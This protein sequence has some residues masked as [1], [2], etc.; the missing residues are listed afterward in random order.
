MT[1]QINLGNTRVYDQ[2]YGKKGINKD[3]MKTGCKNVK[4]ME[5]AQDSAPWLGISSV[6]PNG[7]VPL[8]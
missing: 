7:V 1:T 8:D 4:W 6:G 2:G 3:H 5:L